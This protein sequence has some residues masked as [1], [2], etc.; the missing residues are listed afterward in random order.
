MRPEYQSHIDGLRA[1][2]VLIVIFFHLGWSWLPGGYVGVDV[3]FV[4]SGYLITWMLREELQQTGTLSLKQFYL[5]RIRRLLPALLVMLLFTSAFAALVF[6]PYMLEQFGASLMYA[7]VGLSNHVFWAESNYFDVAAQMKPLLHTWSLSVEE[8]FY[9]IWPGLLLLVFLSG[10]QRWMP[11]VILGLGAASLWLNLW[12]AELSP[13][14]L[15]EVFPSHFSLFANLGPTLFF[16][17]PF[18][19]FEFCIG[20]LLVW[21]PKPENHLA[22]KWDGLFLLGLLMIILSAFTFHEELL[23]PSYLALLPCIGGAL[24]IY[25]GGLARARWILTNRW[26]VFTGLISYSL[27][28]YHWPIIVFWRYLSLDVLSLAEQ[29]L[30]VTASFVLGY[31]SFKFVEQPFRGGQFKLRSQ[32]RLL[33]GTLAV[34]FV[35]IMGTSMRTY[36]G[37]QWR[38]DVPDALAMA[39]GGKGFARE[40]YGGAGYPSV[41][42]LDVENKEAIDMFIVGDSHGKHYVH[43]LDQNL[44]QPQQLN[45]YISAGLSCFHLPNLTRKTPGNWDEACPQAVRSIVRKVLEQPKPPVVVMSHAWVSQMNRAALLGADGKP[46]TGE[47]SREDIMQ[48][49]LEF[50]SAIGDARLIVIGQVPTT[51]GID[52]LDVLTR[53]KLLHIDFTTTLQTSQLR[54]DIRSFNEALRDFG[55][56]S[57]A[58]EFLDPTE[59]LCDG[60]LCIN[61]DD[62]NFPL[63]S[64]TT[65]LSTRGSKSVIDQLLQSHP[66]VLTVNKG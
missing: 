40:H 43:G 23:Y 36:G 27:Y 11:V 42:L 29:L 64:D 31:L 18:R 2:S 17:A 32:H 9:L 35:V 39:E 45:L 51:N 12:F 38:I 66:D 59:V 34:L 4:I 47:I 13:D 48:G 7:V 15:K 22:G 8:Q 57:G 19:V 65:H 3:F 21:L 1:L 10:I 58:Y 46:M 53:P 49:L 60:D 5:R 55:K 20:A 24:V 25:S 63:Y 41:G 62:D 14:A 54:T 30:V 44:V 37:W 28:L 16:L 33:A 6:S 52:P 56:Q 50:K 26:M 61:L